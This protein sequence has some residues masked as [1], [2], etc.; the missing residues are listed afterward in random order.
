MAYH[1]DSI[2]IFVRPLPPGR[3]SFVIGKA[4]RQTHA[5]K[6]KPAAK[7]R[8]NEFLVVKAAVSDETGKTA[9]GV[10]GD[11]PSYGWLDKR[12]AFSSEQKLRRLLDLVQKARQIYLDEPKFASPFEIWLRSYRAIQKMGQAAEHEALTSSFA[13]AL[14]ERAI[15]DAVCRLQDAS[16]FEA[17][18]Q[19]SLGI[20]LAQISPT[21]AKLRLP[22][23]LPQRP[24]TRIFIR[25]TIGGADPLTAADWPERIN[26]GEPETLEEYVERDG[27][28]YFKVKIFGDPERDLAR[29]QRIWDVASAAEEPVLTL[30]GNESYE[31]LET[32]AALVDS[33]ENQAPG[34]FDHLAFIEQP[35]PRALTHDPKTKPVIQR[36]AAKKPLVI[37]EAGGSLAAFPNAFA[38]GY[39]GVSHKNCKGF[40]TSLINLAWIHHF[41]QAT[42]REAFLSGE[43]LSNMPLVPLHQDFAALAVLG[44]DHAERNGHHYTRGLSF[45]TEHEKILTKQH[46]PGLYVERGGELFL[47]IRDGAVDCRSLQTTGFGVAFEP[48]WEALIPLARWARDLR[49]KR[50]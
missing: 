7:R 41:E 28:R 12:P 35:L 26:D 37:D 23:L 22:D 46:H 27:L 16:I 9:T 44:I 38:N 19:D 4:G 50:D 3:M 31:D 42:G 29:L 34:L 39:A 25:H 48:D 24:T 47:N 43:D 30:D 11:R 40:F 49:D 21:L 45:L 6:S 15:L 5:A 2:E 20:D 36:I 17:V 33:I 13:S 32:F 8:P 1:L 14:F 18:R 10:S